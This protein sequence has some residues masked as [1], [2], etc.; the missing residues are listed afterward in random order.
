[1]PAVENNPRHA[2]GRVMKITHKVAFKFHPIFIPLNQLF[3]AIYN[4]VNSFNIN[5]LREN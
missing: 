2:G 5:R 4:G 1:M 3:Q